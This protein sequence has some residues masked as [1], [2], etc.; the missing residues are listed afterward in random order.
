MKKYRQKSD[1]PI[2]FP[3]YLWDNFDYEPLT[4]LL[5]RK[6]GRPNDLG[7]AGGVV[8]NGYIKISIG[9][10]KY[11][12]HRLIWLWLHGTIDNE[13]I[14]H[15]NNDEA[16]NRLINLRCVSLSENQRN[17]RKVKARYEASHSSP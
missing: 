11:F 5:I 6:K 17:L 13:C 9:N 14:D 12:A 8:T 7:P 10:K 15:I 2:Q 3:E 1:P 4:G 16:D